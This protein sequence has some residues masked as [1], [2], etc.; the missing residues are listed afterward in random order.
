MARFLFIL[1][2]LKEFNTRYGKAVLYKK[3]T[4]SEPTRKEPISKED[5]TTP[6]EKDG[7]K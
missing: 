7:A 1:I 5:E 4:A 2:F 3:D 6:S